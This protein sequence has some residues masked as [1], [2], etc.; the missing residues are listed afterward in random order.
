MESRNGI[1]LIKD[2]RRDLKKF[3]IS[4]L[5][6]E[7][8]GW[9]WP[10]HTEAGKF[11]DI[12][13]KETCYSH[14]AQIADI[15]VL[16]LEHQDWKRFKD[17]KERKHLHKEIRKKYEKHL[18][19][20]SDKKNYLSISYRNQEEVD[21]TDDVYKYPLFSESEATLA[22]MFRRKVAES[23]ILNYIRERYRNE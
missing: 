22:R 3:D 4:N 19:C 18:I 16:G 23:Q 17:N 10:L 5:F 7:H 21:I 11:I 13:V 9:E 12:L 20:F 14:I 1:Q 8:L 6:I 2:I 15:P